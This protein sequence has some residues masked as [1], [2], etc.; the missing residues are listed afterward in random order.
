MEQEIEIAKIYPKIEDIWSLVREAHI[1]KAQITSEQLIQDIQIYIKKLE[2]VSVPLFISLAHAY[3]VAG[4]VASM[5]SRDQETLSVIHY[6]Q[7]MECIASTLHDNTLFVI[8]LT[9]KGDAYRRRG[10]LS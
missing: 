7:E 1:Y 9:Y 2:G 5:A 3:H 6:F 8:A 4:Y 10:D